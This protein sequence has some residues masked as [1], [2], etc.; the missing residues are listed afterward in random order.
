MIEDSDEESQVERARIENL[1]PMQL[2]LKTVYVSSGRLNGTRA[3]LPL[4]AF[5]LLNLSGGLAFGVSWVELA[6]LAHVSCSGQV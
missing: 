6:A 5:S 4:L 1:S 2:Q 3:A